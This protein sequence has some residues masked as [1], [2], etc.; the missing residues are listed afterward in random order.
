ML[1]SRGLL[2][3]CSKT[4]RILHQ[5]GS[6]TYHFTPFQE[7]K[8]EFLFLSFPHDLFNFSE[9]FLVSEPFPAEWSGAFGARIS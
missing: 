2:I 6:P 8:P 4:R 1:L 5:P 3:G 7:V 9:R